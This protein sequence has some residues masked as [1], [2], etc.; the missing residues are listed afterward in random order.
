M[1]NKIRKVCEDFATGLELACYEEE[2]FTRK[3]LEDVEYII[4]KSSYEGLELLRNRT[5]DW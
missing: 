5:K 1:L 3:D 4:N 2:L